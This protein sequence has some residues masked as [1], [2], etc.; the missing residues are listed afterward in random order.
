MNAKCFMTGFQFPLDSAVVLNRRDARALLAP[1][2]RAASLRR[3]VDQLA[4]LDDLPGAN[5]ARA[6]LVPWCR[7]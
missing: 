6:S 2:N 5:S 7:R 3:V 4:P 1:N